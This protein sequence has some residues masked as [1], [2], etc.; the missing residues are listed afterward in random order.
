MLRV[1]CL[2][3]ALSAAALCR[4][5]SIA[6]ADESGQP[7][8]PAA[9]EFFEKKVRP[10]LAARCYECH[11][12]DSKPEGGLRLDSRGSIL[13]GGET[14]PAVKPGRPDESL[15]VDA[16]RYGDVF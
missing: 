2:L 11:G 3:F 5:G 16:I 14:G 9:V 8:S 12:P 7:A 15:L 13:K 10:I 1:L 4:C 6:A